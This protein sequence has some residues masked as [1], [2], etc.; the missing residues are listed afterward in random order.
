MN[1]E[2][3]RAYAVESVESRRTIDGEKQNVA[4]DVEN[5]AFEGK[6][7]DGVAKFDAGKV[8]ITRV[9]FYGGPVEEEVVLGEVVVRQVRQDHPPS[10]QQ[11]EM[12]HEDFRAAL[13][14][15]DVRLVRKMWA[16]FMPHLPQPKPSKPK[17]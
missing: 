9:V 13:E 3:F 8:T 6:L 10:S 1:P 15:G 5:P 17:R 4:H 12:R 11:P 2:R 14:A 7:V 16:A